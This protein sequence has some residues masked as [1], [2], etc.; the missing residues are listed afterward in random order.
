MAG[1]FPRC[2]DPF[3]PENNGVVIN[4]AGI[5]LPYFF[6][7]VKRTLLLNKITALNYLRSLLLL[8]IVALLTG[9]KEPR[10]VKPSRLHPDFEKAMNLLKIRKDSAFYYFNKVATSPGDSLQIAKAYANM[11]ILLSDAADPFAVRRPRC[12]H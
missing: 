9:C 11:A 8:F 5:V 6:V 1:I 4:K 7:F 2:Q 12:R 10:K 3:L